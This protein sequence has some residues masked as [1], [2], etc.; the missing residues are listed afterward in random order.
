MFSGEHINS[1]EDRAVFHVALRAPEDA[2]MLDTGVNVIPD[3]HKV[4]KQI[5]EFSEK[6]AFHQNKL[7]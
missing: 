3:V 2:V 5:E 4:L 6:V 7:S 1:T